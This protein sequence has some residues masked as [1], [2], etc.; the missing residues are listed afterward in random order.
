LHHFFSIANFRKSL[1]V[2]FHQNLT[3]TNLKFLF[4]TTAIT[5]T[6]E[7]TSH[8]DG[9]ILSI[10]CL[11][12]NFKQA[13]LSTT[14]IQSLVYFK[15]TWWVKHQETFQSCEEC[16]FAYWERIWSEFGTNKFDKIRFKHINSLR[17]EHS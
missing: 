8:F 14:K 16:Y 4:I 6:V 1:P 7:C 10:W 13:G 5:A 12:S 3:E 11:Q 17:L 9:N 15:P 2:N